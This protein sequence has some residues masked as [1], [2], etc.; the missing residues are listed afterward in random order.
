MTEKRSEKHERARNSLPDELKPAFDELVAD[1]K[2]ATIQQ[3][4]KGY[5]AYGVLAELVRI[6]WRFMGEPKKSE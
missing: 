6:G 2:F 3:F 4:G 5:V 1:Y